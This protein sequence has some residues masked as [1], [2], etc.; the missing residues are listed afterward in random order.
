MW[1]VECNVA[2]SWKSGLEVSGLIH[3]PHF[4]EWKRNNKESLRNVGEILCG[5]L[6]DYRIIQNYIRHAKNTLLLSGNF[7]KFSNNFGDGSGFY[8]SLPIFKNSSTGPENKVEAEPV[9]PKTIN[10]ITT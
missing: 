1:C 8:L 6:P 9:T 3:N 10:I 5:G 2:F 7:E 4:Y